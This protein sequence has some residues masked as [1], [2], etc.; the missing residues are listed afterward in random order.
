M[1]HGLR[2]ALL[3]A[4]PLLAACSSAIPG[5]AS[6]SCAEVPEGICASAR[7]VYRMT[8]PRNASPPS[9]PAAGSARTNG[10]EIPGALPATSAAAPRAESPAPAGPALPVSFGPEGALPLRSPPTVLRVW[11]APWETE[12]GDL[13]M[14][15]Y[16]FTEIAPRRWMVGHSPVPTAAVLRPLEPAGA[17]PAV[18]PPAATPAPPPAM[19]FAP[20]RDMEARGRDE[21]GDIGEGFFA[22]RPPVTAARAP[23][24]APR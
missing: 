19:P 16:V 5:S 11:V 9:A 2:A 6:Y 4:L 12:R 21:E 1:T 10:P 7:E 20:R 22:Q 14:P 3:A 15:G 18:P 24:A 17:G 8:D 23:A 13:N